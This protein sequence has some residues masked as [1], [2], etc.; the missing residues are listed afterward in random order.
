MGLTDKVKEF[1][2]EAKRMGIEVRPPCINQSVTK[3]SVEDGAIRYGLGALKGLGEKA[4]DALVAARTSGTSYVDLHDLARRWNSRVANKTCYETLAKAGAFAATGWTRR[5]V[6]ESVEIALRE[7]AHDQADL[8]K[9]QNLLFGGG[10]TTDSGS[11]EKAAI[12][13]V[14]EWD[15]SAKLSLEKEAIGFFLSGHPFERQG[16]FYSLLAGHDTRSVK[17]LPAEDNRSEIIL[18]GMISGLR[19]MVIKNGR[20]AGQRMARFRL[21]DLHGSVGATVFSKQYQVVHD[22]LANDALVFVRARLDKSGDEP[23]ILIDE[24]HDAESYVRQH[25]D[26]LVLALGEQDAERL[27]LVRETLEDHPGSHR[28]MLVV[29]GK[30]GARFRLMADPDLGVDL[31]SDLLEGLTARLGSGALSFTRR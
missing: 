22:K 19:P 18:A 21:E 6:L 13:D 1:I 24:V 12:P 27:P 28:V 14:P 11:A 9:G 7:A 17:S 16:R 2:D 23:A 4:A 15:E 26:A 10:P 31:S 8:A 30:N 5:A 25:V 20:N 3:F 29:D